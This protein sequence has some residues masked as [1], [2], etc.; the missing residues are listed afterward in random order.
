[1]EQHLAKSNNLHGILKL[2]SL[3]WLL[4]LAFHRTSV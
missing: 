1:M 3:L 2:I 4:I